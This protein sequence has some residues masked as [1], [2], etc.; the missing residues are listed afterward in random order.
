MMIEMQQNVTKPD[1]H[2][3]FDE[4]QKRDSDYHGSVDVY[5]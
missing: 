5:Q 2:N 1:K 4:T 3:K